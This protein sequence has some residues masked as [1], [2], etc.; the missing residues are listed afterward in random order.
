MTTVLLFILSVWLAYYLARWFFRSVMPR[1]VMWGLNRHIRKKYG[2]AYD[3]YS[4]QYG[5]TQDGGRGASGRRS[6]RGSAARHRRRG[7]IIP[8]DVGEYV[9]FEEIPTYN[10]PSTE[11]TAKSD[12]N[13][14][15]HKFKDEPQ[16]SDADWEDIK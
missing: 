6:P 11:N 10:K 15:T 16:I 8:K 4:Q 7:K 1:I 14:K 5:G 13:A 2:S 12:L 9:E 3:Q